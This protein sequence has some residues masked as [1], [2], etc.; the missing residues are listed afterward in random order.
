MIHIALPLLVFV[1]GVLLWVVPRKPPSGPPP[2]PLWRELGRACLYCGAFA[3][4][5][6][7]TIIRGDYGHLGDVIVAYWSVIAFVVGIVMYAATDDPWKEIGSALLWTGLL[8][9]LVADI[10]HSVHLG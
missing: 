8:V 6:L 10:G 1:A 9:T 7:V 2:N 5:W 4:L 3:T